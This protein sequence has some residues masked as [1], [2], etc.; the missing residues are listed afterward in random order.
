VLVYMG[1][2]S[3]YLANANDAR[4]PTR[5]EIRHRLFACR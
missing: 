2:E 4:Q 1:L 3:E 5:L